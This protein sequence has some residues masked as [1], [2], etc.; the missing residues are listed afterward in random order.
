MSDLMLYMYGFSFFYGATVMVSFY[1]FCKRP[2]QRRIRDAG[3][4]EPLYLDVFMGG[5]MVYAMSI[6]LPKSFALKMRAVDAKTIIKFSTPKDYW[7]AIACLSFF[8]PFT[9]TAVIEEFAPSL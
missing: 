5:Y 2:I 1:L 4:P 6:A 9:I 8:I 3:L 7:M